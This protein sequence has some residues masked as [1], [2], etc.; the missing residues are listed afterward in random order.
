[1]EIVH[2]PFGRRGKQSLLPNYLRQLLTGG[3]KDLTV[4]RQTPGDESQSSVPP[5]QF[6]GLA[7]CHRQKAQRMAEG[8]HLFVKAG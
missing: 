1:M 4:I 6:L 7:G 3:E 5:S 8:G 2:Q